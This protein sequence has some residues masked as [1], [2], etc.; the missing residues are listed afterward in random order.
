MDRC[1]PSVV[2]RR[3][4]TIPLDQPA[5]PSR[6]VDGSPE[7]LLTTQCLPRGALGPGAPSGW[8]RAPQPSGG[9]RPVPTPLEILDGAHARIRI[10]VEKA[11]QLPDA[12]Q[13]LIRR[14]VAALDDVLALLRPLAAD[15]D[16]AHARRLAGASGSSLD[17]MNTIVH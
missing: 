5:G 12:R 8:T 17:C 6:H 4:R 9:E 1:P 2:A 16:R 3:E 10:D 14:D 13:G 7:A 11:G 15:R